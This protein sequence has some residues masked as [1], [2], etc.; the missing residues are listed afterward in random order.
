MASTEKNNLI[1]EIKGEYDRI[2]LRL[3]E[4]QQIIGQSQAEVRRLQQKTIEVQTQMSRIEQNFDTVPRGPGRHIANVVSDDP[5]TP[6]CN[7]CLED[8]F[9]ARIGDDMHQ[10]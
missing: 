7:C 5:L 6:G 4:L 8:Q 10:C 1:A 9:I 3:R 2:Q